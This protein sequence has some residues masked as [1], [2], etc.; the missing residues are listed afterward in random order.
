MS[1]RERI[2]EQLDLLPETELDGI[3]RLLQARTDAQL[4]RSLPA[5]AAESLLAR[6]WLT[7]EED[8]AWAHL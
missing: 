8:E 2:A 3:L 4:D 5:L 6:D 7:P 1:T